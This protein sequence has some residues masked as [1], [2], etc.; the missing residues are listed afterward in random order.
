M[1]SFET[2]FFTFCLGL[3][4]DFRIFRGQRRS[5][6]IGWATLKN[7]TVIGNHH[8]IYPFAWTFGFHQQNWWLLLWWVDNGKI[9]NI[10]ETN[11]TNSWVSFVE[12][13]CRGTVNEEISAFV[14]N[15]STCCI[16][17]TDCL[18]NLHQKP[19]IF[20]RNAG[21]LKEVFGGQTPPQNIVSEGVWSC[22]VYIHT[23]ITWHNI[24]LHYLTLPYLAFPYSTLHSIPLHY[25]TYV[26]TI[27]YHTIPYHTVPCP[28]HAQAMPMPCRTITS[29]HPYIHYITLHYLTLPYLTLH[30]I[31][32]HYIT[33]II[34]YIY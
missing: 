9:G 21:V 8:P 11:Q 29:I 6:E 17:S 14:P 33:Y 23:N 10:P 4:H 30:Y 22:R 26:R 15:A 18:G 20:P 25:I 1:P 31:T 3:T 32:L 5:E 19:W 34:I 7:R 28:S 13:F 2:W 12:E 27:P 16:Y 24:M